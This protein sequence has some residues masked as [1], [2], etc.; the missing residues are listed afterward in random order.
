MATVAAEFGKGK[1]L[2]DILDI[3]PTATAGVIKKAYFKLALKCEISQRKGRTTKQKAK[4]CGRNTGVPYFRRSPSPISSHSATNTRAP[5]RRSGMFWERTRS[6][7]GRW[8][9][10]WIR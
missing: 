2:Y 8:P 6:T 7:R 10:L 4:S 5:T 1:S 9:R 3:P